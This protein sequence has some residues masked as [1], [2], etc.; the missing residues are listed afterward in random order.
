MPDPIERTRVD[1]PPRDPH[2]FA[3]GSTAETVAAPRQTRASVHI[4]TPSTDP[5]VVG[6]LGPYQVLKQLGKGGMGAVY[7]ALDTRLDRKVALKVML[8]EYA[9]DTEARER[10]LREARAAAKVTHDHVVTV[11]EADE[12]DGVP[13][14][15]M[16]LLQGYPLDEYLKTKGAP[17]LHHI[18]RIAHET[19]LGLAAAH[20]RGLVHR[21]IKPANLWLEAPNGRVKLLDFGLAKPLAPTDELTKSGEVVG[22]P[23]YMSPE[24]ARG[25]KVDHRTD[26]FSLGAVL[27][28]LCT[29]R[30]PFDGPS[31]MDVIIAL[32]TADPLPVRQINPK[33]PESLAA[34]IHRLL[35]KDPDRRPQTAAEVARHLSAIFDEFLAARHNPPP[36]ADLS[37]SQP[38]VVHPVP[39]PVAPMA[40]PDNV[41][42]DL[43]A[44]DEATEAELP[45]PRTPEPARRAGPRR[46]K[47]TGAEPSGGK[48]LPL[49]LGAVVLFAVVVAGAIIIKIKNKDGTETEIKV[50]AG[51]TVTIEKNGKEVAKVAP[52][53]GK[54]VAPDP[55]KD[56]R[57]AAEW[58][59]SVGGSVEVDG[60]QKV[61]KS[62]PELPKGAFKLTGVSISN[63]QVTDADCAVFAGC[64]DLWRLDLRGTRVTDAGLVH[65]K[66]CRSIGFLLLMNMRV[67]DAG[68]VHFKDCKGLAVLVLEGTQV[69]GDGLV[70]FA[71]RP[72]LTVVSLRNTPATDTAL[73]HLKDT[74]KL[75]HVHL[76]GTRITDAGLTHLKNNSGLRFLDLD[77]TRVTDAGL[78]TCEHFRSLGHIN[79][80]GLKITDAGLEHVK[81][82][83]DLGSLDLTGTPVTDAG[84]ARV[85]ECKKLGVLFLAGTGVTDGGLDQL[86]GLDQLKMLDVS[87][88]KV[89]AAGAGKLKKALPKC[90]VVRN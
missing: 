35:A 79:L 27:Y 41:F 52:D 83:A 21:D 43:D 44:K 70:H 12:R 28:R 90:T 26:L 67:T 64:T 13:Y 20:A 88:T 58:V 29:G 14:I 17:G 54:K 34:L 75:G 72:Q 60:E 5:G 33:V 1:T 4:F 42:A 6:T 39:Q 25:Q 32:G 84:L 15:A 2:A 85:A 47:P 30:L 50:P 89:T 62:A 40:V 16:Q 87:K 78:K 56:N 49:V 63:E 86:A 53:T 71:D 36:P 11:H 10:F 7:L 22:T 19:A 31:T 18:I 82:C 45:A 68:L 24:Q 23:A 80:A 51:A 57:T 77:G 8:P 66:D 59:L 37:R 46:K 61:L 9:R 55:V 3:S 69:T 38:V 74:T 48:T 76:S 65:F 73:V 81:G